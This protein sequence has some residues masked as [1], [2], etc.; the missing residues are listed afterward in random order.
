[1]PPDIRDGVAALD[2]SA[3]V[4]EAKRR[5]KR[6]GLTRKEHA[7]L[8]GVSA[9]TLAAFDRGET[10]LTLAKAFDIL[11]IVGLVQETSPMDAQGRFVQEAHARWRVLTQSLPA[12]APARFPHGYYQVDYCFEGDLVPV[13]PHRLEE[14]LGR[15]LV[16]YTGWP[17]FWLPTREEIAPRLVDDILECWMAPSSDE[18]LR[19][20]DD[21]AHCD[22]WRAAPSGRMFL[23]RGYQEDSE[24]TFPPGRIFDAALPVWRMGE[25]FL[26]A[27]S[28]ARQLARDP[29]KAV[30]HLRA[31]YTGLNA[32]ELRNWANPTGPRLFERDAVSKSDEAAL[33]IRL[34]L[35]EVEPHLDRHLTAFLWPLYERFGIAQLPQSHVSA[36]L[37][38]MRRRAASGG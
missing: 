6:E 9:P 14:I 23:I 13:E 38:R 34:P 25:V 27:A 5:R 8:A 2:W 16:R 26:H 30:L 18:T 15:A 28:L 19:R 29:D 36:E 37:D 1:M 11:R 35:R 12:D 20:F 24:E 31:I 4:A 10:S 21:A 33:A 7:A 17:P 22:F 32:R 3:L